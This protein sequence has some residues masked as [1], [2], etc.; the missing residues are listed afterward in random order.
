MLSEMSRSYRGH[1]TNPDEHPKWLDINELRKMMIGESHVWRG[2]EN[3]K[4]FESQRLEN[5]YTSGLILTA[6]TPLGL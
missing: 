1:N 6:C 5:R 4:A 2:R 3:S